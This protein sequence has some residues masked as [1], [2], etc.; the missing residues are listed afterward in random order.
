MSQF[1]F[2]HFTNLK[3]E[4]VKQYSTIGY[5]LC[6]QKCKKNK[7]YKNTNNYTF[8]MAVTHP[9]FKIFPFV[10]KICKK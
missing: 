10:F 6:K 7:K 3:E 1:P 4:N 2:L 5:V 8:S 9:L